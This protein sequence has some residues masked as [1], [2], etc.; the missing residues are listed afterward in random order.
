MVFSLVKHS[1]IDLERRLTGVC[2]WG[3]GVQWGVGEGWVC[4]PEASCS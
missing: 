3:G 1:L 4:V 2:V